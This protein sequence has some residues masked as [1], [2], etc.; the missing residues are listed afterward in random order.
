MS[1]LLDSP[2]YYI[3]LS[4][5]SISYLSLSPKTGQ[6]RGTIFMTGGN[7]F[8]P[9]KD[10]ARNSSWSVQNQHSTVNSSVPLP[11]RPLNYKDNEDMKKP[12]AR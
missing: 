7:Q 2:D 10:G 12:T 6:G 9:N 8:C 5:N 11:F 4:I 1:E 3:S